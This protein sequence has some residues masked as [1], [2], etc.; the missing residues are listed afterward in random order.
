VNN[1]YNFI[2]IY[3]ISYAYLQIGDDI[4]S[5]FVY[6]NDWFNGREVRFKLNEVICE[7]SG[8]KN[9]SRVVSIHQ[10]KDDTGTF[11]FTAILKTKTNEIILCSN[12]P[13]ISMKGFVKFIPTRRHKM[14]RLYAFYKSAQ[15]AKKAIAIKTM[16]HLNTSI[17]NA[18]LIL[19]VIRSS[20]EVNVKHLALYEKGYHGLDP[21]FFGMISNLTKLKILFL[22][23][24][25][26]QER[27]WNSAKRM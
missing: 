14:H 9:K 15:D 6:T 27:K 23:R 26:R 25:R 11:L 8:V 4:S 3:I 19:K 10:Q 22:K 17:L 12:T 21:Q 13:N 24:K 7:L 5:Q 16:F 2:N 18:S 20:S 1:H